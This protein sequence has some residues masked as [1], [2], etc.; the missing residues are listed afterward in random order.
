MLTALSIPNVREKVI[1][2]ISNQELW[3]TMPTIAVSDLYPLGWVAV[4]LISAQHI[5][6]SR[7]PQ[8]Q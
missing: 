4:S 2:D 5:G 7:C 1:D 6:E 3:L 8:V